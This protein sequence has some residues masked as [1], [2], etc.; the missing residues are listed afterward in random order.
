M[1]VMSKEEY[2]SWSERDKQVAAEGLQ[3]EMIS[4]KENQTFIREKITEYILA[5]HAPSK[6]VAVLCGR[7]E[8]FLP[9]VYRNRYPDTDAAVLE[10]TFLDEAIKRAKAFVWDPESEIGKY[11]SKRNKDS[12]FS[13]PTKGT[14]MYY[15]TALELEKLRLEEN[16]FAILVCSHGCASVFTGRI[17]RVGEQPTLNV[18]KPGELPAKATDLE[19]SET[20]QVSSLAPE[21]Y[22]PA[23]PLRSEGVSTDS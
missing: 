20:A 15:L 13:L 23:P 10:V 1:P 11:W 8:P 18:S 2:A 16:E 19:P 22:P 3:R 4:L 14:Q 21:F 6:L 12:N 17:P 9:D 7:N 5:G